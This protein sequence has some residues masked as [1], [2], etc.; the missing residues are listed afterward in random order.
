MNRCQFVV[1]KRG[2]LC[3]RNATDKG[4]CYEHFQMVHHVKPWEYGQ[5]W[6]SDGVTRWQIPEVAVLLEEATDSLQRLITACGA[7]GIPGAWLD[8]I[9]HASDRVAEQL[10]RLS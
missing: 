9:E 6:R 3:G 2:R 7:N 1:G 4:Y 8:R 5:G 10:R